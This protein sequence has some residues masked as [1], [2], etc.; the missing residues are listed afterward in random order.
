MLIACTS[1]CSGCAS[2]TLSTLRFAS[3]VKLAEMRPPLLEEARPG[4]LIARNKF[5]E[6]RV[7]QLE[8][9]LKSMSRELQQQQQQQHSEVQVRRV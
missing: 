7:K 2:E 3:R 9:Q 8:A 1:P 4:E 5:L 6:K